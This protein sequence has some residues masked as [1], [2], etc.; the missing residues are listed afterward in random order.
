MFMYLHTKFMDEFFGFALA[1]VLNVYLYDSNICNSLIEKLGIY[2]G[3][4]IVEQ[5]IY[6]VDAKL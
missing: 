4:Y 3:L 5:I 6:Q 2:K 1:L